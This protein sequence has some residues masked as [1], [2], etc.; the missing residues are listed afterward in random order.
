MIMTRWAE[1]QGHRIRFATVNLAAD[2]AEIRQR[3]LHIVGAYV[4]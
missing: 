2:S 3:L 1:I 4:Q